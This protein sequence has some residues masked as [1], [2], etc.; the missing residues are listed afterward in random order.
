[1][2]AFTERAEVRA[3]KELPPIALMF[4]HVMDF[5]LQP[6]T[7]TIRACVR[8]FHQD[9]LPQACPAHGAVEFAHV[10][11]VAYFGVVAPTTVALPA[12]HQDL[13][14]HTGVHHQAASG[15]P[16][17]QTMLSHRSQRKKS[18]I[19]RFLYVFCS[20]THE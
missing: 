17:L 11:V 15:S 10:L 20:L 3:I 6:H 18:H 16:V 9:L 19:V 1:M 8:L 13:T 12:L 2:A 4:P 14:V 5:E 7:L